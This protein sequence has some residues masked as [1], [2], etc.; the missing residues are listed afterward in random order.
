MEHDSIDFPVPFIIRGREAVTTVVEFTHHSPERI[1]P[2]G[3]NDAR[4]DVQLTDRARW[5]TVLEFRLWVD[6]NA[7]LGRYIAHDNLP[8]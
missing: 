3:C 1:L 5:K 7:E 2:S 4:L 8:G 6:P